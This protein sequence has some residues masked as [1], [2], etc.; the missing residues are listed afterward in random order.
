MP[1]FLT[2][3][4]KKEKLLG[5]YLIDVTLMFSSAVFMVT[6]SIFQYMNI[7]F[8]LNQINNTAV[9]HALVLPAGGDLT[10]FLK[11]VLTCHVCLGKLLLQEES[12]S[13]CNC[14]T[15]RP[16]GDIE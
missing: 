9:G 7:S 1:S 6:S 5:G 12:L 14:E 4:P 3:L 11:N 2:L 10:D 15:H 13:S 16:Q 8:C